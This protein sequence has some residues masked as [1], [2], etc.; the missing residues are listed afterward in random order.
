MKRMEFLYMAIAL[1]IGLL[2]FTACGDDNSTTNDGGGTQLD[3]KMV[4]GYWALTHKKAKDGRYDKDFPTAGQEG[5]QELFFRDPQYLEHWTYEDHEWK[6]DAK[7]N[8]TI[9][10]RVIT[11]NGMNITVVSL[12]TSELIIDNGDE[13][14][15]CKKLSKSA[16]NNNDDDSPV[17]TPTIIGT[18][19]IITIIGSA[20][21]YGTNNVVDSWNNTPTINDAANGK[22]S[23]KYKEFTFNENGEFIN[24]QF[25][26]D[27]RTF[28]E[29]IKGNWTVEGSTLK[30]V[31]EGETRTLDIVTL[32]G[33]K[34][35]LHVNYVDDDFKVHATGQR[36]KVTYDETMTFERK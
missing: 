20:T 3:T 32:T 36:L 9:N 31:I 28:T 15:T 2:C 23:L 4:N 7:G 26:E 21:E 33:N 14:I 30:V 17:A 16:M 34:L 19:K 18:W 11:I 24:Q 10:G 27:K 35:A 13:I 5:Y 22:E 12:T 6:A 29:I 25:D 1:V 8:Y